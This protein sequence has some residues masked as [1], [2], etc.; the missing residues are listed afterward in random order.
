V[1]VDVVGDLGGER[2]QRVVGESRHVDDGVEALQLVDGDVPQVGAEAGHVRGVE[3]AEHAVGE[4]AAV[5]PGHLV[6]CRGED[7][8]HHGAQVALVTGQQNSHGDPF[9]WFVWRGGA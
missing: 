8:G 9:E 2:T 4:Q 3:R 7:R 5:E 6:A 1:V